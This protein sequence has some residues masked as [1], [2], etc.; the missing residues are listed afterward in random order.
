MKLFL[1]GDFE[2]D[3]GPGNANKQIRDSIAAE[4]NVIYSQRSGRIGRILEMYKGIEKSDLLIICSKSNINFSA[5][6]AAKRQEKKIIYLMHGYASQEAQ[7][8]NPTITIEQ[9]EQI[10]RY[11]SIVYGA[12]DCIVCV[13]KK[14]M[15]Y[16]QR[17]LPQYKN[18]IDYIYNVVDIDYIKKI[19]I[20]NP[21]IK[22]K[23]KVLS[24]GGGMRQKN[25]LTVARAIKGCTDYIEYVVVGTCQEDGEEIQKIDCVT[26][27]DHLSHE[28]LLRLMYECSLYIQNSTFETFGLS[29]IEAL[30]AGCSLL[31]S[32]EVGC[33]DIFDSL[34]DEDIIYDVSDVDEIYKKIE[35]L[36]LNPNNKRLLSGFKEEKVSK[37]FQA[38]RWKKIIDKT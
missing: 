24:V 11:E 16:M 29:V 25:N 31:I 14:C 19:C 17:Q 33:L 18:K 23:N 15:E 1:L 4:Y 35:H 10:E 6:R 36:L 3:N 30:Y 9:L 34:S 32:N 13:S 20:S 38:G 12:A 26:W 21:P 8:A 7:I 27:M 5:I 2:S 22:K 28:K 37:S